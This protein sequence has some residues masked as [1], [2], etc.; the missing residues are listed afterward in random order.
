MLGVFIEEMYKLTKEQ[1]LQL[2]NRPY[3]WRLKCEINRG[4]TEGVSRCAKRIYRHVFLNAEIVINEGLFNMS[5]E[6]HVNK[7]C[8]WFSKT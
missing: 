5:K 8:K 4:C 2:Y 3:L 1:K 7:F 6:Q